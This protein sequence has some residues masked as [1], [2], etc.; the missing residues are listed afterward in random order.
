LERLGQNYRADMAALF[1]VVVE[2]VVIGEGAAAA[3][4]RLILERAVV[5]VDT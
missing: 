4:K 5:V 3:L 2:V 1:S